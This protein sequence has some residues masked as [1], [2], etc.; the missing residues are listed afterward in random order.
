MGECLTNAEV[1]DLLSG[2]LSDADRARVEAHLAACAGCRRDVEAAQRD[3]P[4]NVPGDQGASPKTRTNLDDDRSAGGVEPDPIRRGAVRDSI[5]GYEILSEIHRGGQGIVYKAV[6]KSTRR[7]VAIKVLPEWASASSRR[8][9]RFEREINLVAGL[10]HPNIV[11]VYESGLTHDRYYFAMEYIHGRPLDAYLAD[12]K[13]STDDVLRLMAKVCRA[14]AYAHN[15][16][17]IHR[18]IKPGNILVDSEGEPHIVDFGLA[19]AAGTGLLAGDTPVTVTSEFMGT[20]AFAS[21][22]QVSGDPSLVDVRTDI[23][24][25]GVVLHKSLTDQHPFDLSGDIAHLLARIA[26]AD[27][28]R[29]S[30]VRGELKG[31][32]DT[33]ILKAL[34]KERDR[35]YQ[36]AADLANDLERV[37]RGEPIE[38]RS[39]SIAYVLRKRCRALTQRHPAATVLGGLVL[40]VLIT[41]Y[42]GVRLIFR[43]TPINLM[44][45]RLAVVCFSPPAALQAFDQVRIVALTDKTDV[46][47]LARAE[48]LTGISLEDPTSLR[49]LHGRLMEKLAA[50]HARVIVCYLTFCSDTV[51]DADF[52]K[53]VRA[54]REQDVPVIV[55]ASTW[56]LDEQG[57]PVLSKTIAP[58]V[59]WGHAAQRFNPQGPWLLE[60]VMQ[61]GG[62]DVRPSLALVAAAACR[63]PTAKI[64]LALDAETEVVETTFWQPN[65]TIPQAKVRLSEASSRVELYGVGTE[66]ADSPN[67]GLQ[68]GDKIG[69]F[70][71]NVPANDVLAS[72]TLEYAQVFTA[73]PDQLRAWLGD[74]VVMITDIRSGTMQC[75][76]PD[77]RLLAPCYGHAAAIDALLHTQFHRRPGLFGEYVVISAGA[78]LGLLALVVSSGRWLVCL[79]VLVL[80]SGSLVVAGFAAYRVFQ[81]MCNPFM[82]MLAMV[83][84][85]VLLSAVV[86]ARAARR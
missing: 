16:G 41:Q 67:W 72:S 80:L 26:H 68:R 27:P 28:V 84:T 83:L 73:D 51:F 40:V 7:T 45:E 3:G 69:Y 66:E 33:I 75:G 19:K 18:D 5:E 56:Y 12:R 63:E 42:V 1:E 59:R 57:L 11:T 61:R 50:A 86:P 47:G 14:I 85:C 43:W 70:L 36:S 21:P 49:R 10:R 22:E 82:P 37:L 23:Y 34:A 53:G 78:L 8:R 76:H 54:L 74:K 29:P 2:R 32:L 60:M 20:L 71:V 77:G 62:S 39:D 38:A 46:L 6:Q 30:T 9:H 4:G 48:G 55:S 17:V 58:A 35:R 15:Q 24:S 52:V 65:P 81:Y 31:D 13:Q 44:F 79:P 25:L 64:D